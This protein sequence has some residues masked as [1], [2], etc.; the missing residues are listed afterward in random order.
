MGC[1]QTRHYT[2]QLSSLLSGEEPGT[3][4][5][6]CADLTDADKSLPPHPLRAVP[7]PGDE[8]LDETE[9]QSA[10]AVGGEL[11]Q[12]GHH[13][14]QRERA[15]P[16]AGPSRADSEQHFTRQGVG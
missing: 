1:D 15:S 13:L 16:E 10:R 9:P 11:P 7:E 5:C 2:S 3:G 14:Q 6:G 12:H 4:S 8:L